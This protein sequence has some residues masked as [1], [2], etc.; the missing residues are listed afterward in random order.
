M[1]ARASI[2]ADQY[3]RELEEWAKQKQKRS[4]GKEPRQEHGA[5]IDF[6]EAKRRLRG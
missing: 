4:T 6:R 1:K 2:P 3:F 5:V